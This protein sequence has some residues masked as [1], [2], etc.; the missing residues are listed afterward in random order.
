MTMHAQIF[1]PAAPLS[2]RPDTAP[3]SLVGAWRRLSLEYAD[4][5]GDTQTFALWLQG[6]RFFADLRVPSVSICRDVRGFADLDEAQALAMAAQDGFAGQFEWQDDTCAWHRRIDFRSAGGRGEGLI[7]R[8]RR[9]LIE[10]G[11][12]SASVEHWWQETDDDPAAVEESFDP[13]RRRLLVR[14]GDTAI[15]AHERRSSPPAGDHFAEAVSIAARAADA[16]ALRSLLDCEI[17]LARLS[18]G[19]WIVERST[20]PW[21]EGC[22]LDASV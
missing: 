1:T 21:R 19:S 17:S 2:L 3:R 8:E 9:M 13:D 11:W 16:D 18:G 4:G 10:T 15:L 22:R 5:S 20:L 14:L 12:Q 7:K 6:H